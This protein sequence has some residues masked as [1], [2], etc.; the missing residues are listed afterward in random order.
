MKTFKELVESGEWNQKRFD[1]IV[2]K[3]RFQLQTPVMKNVKRCFNPE[4]LS[5]PDGMATIVFSACERITLDII[6]EV[7]MILYHDESIIV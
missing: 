3:Y 6:H 2:Q 5:T 7:L 4:S 1:G